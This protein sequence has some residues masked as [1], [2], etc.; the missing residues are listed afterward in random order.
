MGP[1]WLA[2]KVEVKLA[3]VGGQG[4][5]LAGHI[6]ALGAFYDGKQVVCTQAYSARVRGAPVEADVI[7]SDERIR[8]PFVRRPDVLVIL[9]EP[10]L[11]FTSS[12]AE[13]GLILADR[14]LEALL[15]DVRAR[16][17]VL[18]LVETAEREA[19]SGKLANMVALG[20][21]VASTGLVSTSS[22][23]KA[24]SESVGKRFI[25]VDLRAFRA[26]LNLARGTP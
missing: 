2:L 20:A 9:A 22:M 7:I 26:G 18:P 21:L 11:R 17:L 15:S 12:L 5:V 4:I 13:E 10:G 3:G 6:L 1:W 14:T 25:D 24:I 8:Y 23:E 16:K 19:G